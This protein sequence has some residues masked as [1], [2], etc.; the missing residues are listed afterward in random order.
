MCALLQCYKIPEKVLFSLKIPEGRQSTAYLHIWENEA[1]LWYSF[2][3]RKSFVVP[4]VVAYPDRPKW[5]VIAN[6]SEFY[7]SVYCHQMAF[8]SFMLSFKETSLKSNLLCTRHF[9]KS[10]TINTCNPPLLWPTGRSDWV[11]HCEIVPM[12]V[13]ATLKY[14]L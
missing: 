2:R 1:F 10:F 13:R 14:L 11:E 3:F 6:C 8:D 12:L 5:V 9:I 7:F 4:V